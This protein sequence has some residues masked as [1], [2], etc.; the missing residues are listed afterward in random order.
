MPFTSSPVWWRPRDSS[1]R[2]LEEH[3]QR[4]TQLVPG[5]HLATPPFVVDTASF[6]SINDLACWWIDVIVCTPYLF[7]LCQTLAL[8]INMYTWSQAV[9]MN[10]RV[11][12]IM[13]KQK[14][15][16]FHC[17]QRLEEMS[18]ILSMS[19]FKVSLFIHVHSEL[20]SRGSCNR[21]AT[22]QPSRLKGSFSS[23]LA[24]SLLVTLW[25][26]ERTDR[27]ADWAHR[28]NSQ[29]P[30][31]LSSILCLRHEY[32]WS[33]VGLRS[34][35]VWHPFLHLVIISLWVDE[36]KKAHY[37]T[38]DPNSCTINRLYMQSIVYFYICVFL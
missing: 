16:V 21:A 8:N 6:Q 27:R 5:A 22:K 12:I 3:F 25:T 38:S 20:K 15:Q 17:L 7:Y 33:A 19:N 32:Q 4:L 34:H 14:S 37:K 26:C 2:G 29:I 10:I 24:L 30:V 11:F 18:N 35:T 1:V 31:E 13:W 28:D 23:S 36:F 9:I